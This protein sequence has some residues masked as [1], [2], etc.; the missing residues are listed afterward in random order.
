MS[1]KTFEELS[2]TD[3]T[4]FL[5]ALDDANISEEQRQQVIYYGPG[6]KDD[7]WS[8][9]AIQCEAYGPAGEC[10]R[11]A[12]HLDGAWPIGVHVSFDSDHYGDWRVGTISLAEARKRLLSS[13]L[14]APAES[15]EE[16]Q[17]G[18]TAAIAQVQAILRGCND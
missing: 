5:L 16:F 8:T 9:E 17:A 1:E 10:C 6:I 2:P 18:F 13:G 4:L 12:G 15:S 3:K 14:P 7:P 11:E